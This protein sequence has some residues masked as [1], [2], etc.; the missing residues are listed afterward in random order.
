MKVLRMEV[1]KKMDD[2]N[3]ILLNNIPTI[4][5]EI[6]GVAIGT[7]HLVIWHLVDSIFDHF[8]GERVAKTW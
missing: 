3:K 7:G 8:L 4:L 5:E 6:P 1:P 2:S